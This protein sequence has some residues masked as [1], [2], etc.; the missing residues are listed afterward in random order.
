M[1]AK[2]Q[3]LIWLMLA[4][5]ETG[6]LC[7]AAANESPPAQRRRHAVEWRSLDFAELRLPH[8]LRW[9]YSTECRG[10]PVQRGA[11]SWHQRAAR[12][13]YPADWVLVECQRIR[14]QLTVGSWTWQVS[15]CMLCYC[16]LSMSSPRPTDTQFVL[17]TDSLH[18]FTVTGGSTLGQE[19]GGHMPHRF[20]C[21]PLQIQKLAGKIFTRSKMPIFPL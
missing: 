3:S 13:W 4:A 12:G 21:C 19:G 17:Y 6:S 7:A 1:S 20:T 9:R 5:S 16:W 2:V 8:Q 18:S 15:S 11:V 14:W 10:N